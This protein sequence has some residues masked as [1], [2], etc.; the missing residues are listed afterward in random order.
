MRFT[1]EKA[2]LLRAAT[3]ASLAVRRSDSAVLDC[4]QI[5][6]DDR[7]R[8]YGSCRDIEVRAEAKAGVLSQGVTLVNSRDFKAIVSATPNNTSLTVEAKDDALEINGLGIEAKLMTIPADSFPSLTPD[9]E[10]AEV[11]GGADA[12]AL[13]A[14]FAAKEE[15]RFHMRGVCIDGDYAVAGDGPRIASLPIQCDQKGA[16]IPLE[17]IPLVRKLIGQDGRLWVG[18][19]TWR[20]EAEWVQA[21]GRLIDGQFPERWRQIMPDGEGLFTAHTADLIG[22][23][24]ASTLSRAEWL[25]I[26]ASGGC[27]F[28]SGDKFGGVLA[29]SNIQCP[30]TVRK[31]FCAVVTARYFKSTIE[32]FGDQE[33]ALSGA[34]GRLRF[35]AES[36]LSAAMMTLRDNRNSLPE[37]SKA[38]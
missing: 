27:L 32:A 20:L 12:L 8:L 7:L 13:C 34:S 25:V 17:S 22:A 37:T 1:A 6:A 9:R 2:P 36:G 3:E 10:M 38:A 26:K 11:I 23:C 33:I 4:L 18:P 16:I 19:S 30:A 28:L 14:P 31:D 15:A 5:V 21:A 35:D 24:N 29:V